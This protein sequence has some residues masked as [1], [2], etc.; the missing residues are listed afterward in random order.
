MADGGHLSKGLTPLPTDKQWAK[1]FYGQR[2]GAAYRNSTVSS[3][4]QFEIVISGLASVIL[5][6]LSIVNLQ[7]HCQFVPVS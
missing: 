5:I 7:F 3:D 1:S 4:S 6:V 2:E